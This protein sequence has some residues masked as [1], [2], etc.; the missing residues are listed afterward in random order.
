MEIPLVIE[1]RREIDTEFVCLFGADDDR[2]GAGE[3]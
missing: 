2:S 1:L 3:D